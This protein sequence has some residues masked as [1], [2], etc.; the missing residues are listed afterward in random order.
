MRKNQTQRNHAAFPKK[1][2]CLIVSSYGDAEAQSV[3]ARRKY[4][5]ACS[6]TSY[7]LVPGLTAACFSTSVSICSTLSLAS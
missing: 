3:S 2:F 6:V 4:F 7:P 1:H 5:F